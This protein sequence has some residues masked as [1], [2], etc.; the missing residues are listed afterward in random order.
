MSTKHFPT[1]IADLPVKVK[2]LFF[3]CGSVAFALRKDDINP[4]VQETL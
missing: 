2:L 4:E 1:S 3:A